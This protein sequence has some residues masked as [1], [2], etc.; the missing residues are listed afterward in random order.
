ME[1]G[2]NYPLN[3][4][5]S[6]FTLAEWQKYKGNYG[7]DLLN[8]NSIEEVFENLPNYV[9]TQKTFPPLWKQRLIINNREFYETYKKFIKD[10]TI[11]SIK[12][13]DQESWKKLEWNCKGSNKNF[14]DKLIQFRGSGVRIKKNDYIPSL[15]TVSTQVPII[16][17]YMRY[18][19]PEEGAKTQSLPDYIKLPETK[20]GS[21]RVL[22]NMVN[23]ELVYKIAS[24]LLKSYNSNIPKIKLEEVSLNT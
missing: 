4:D 11:N 17:K 16:G 6:K 23:V 8:C 24:A 3:E 9:K 5:W 13:L 10:S 18:I 15:V 21:F 7:Y 19:L 2:A 1:F 20:S 14:T 22:G 12:N